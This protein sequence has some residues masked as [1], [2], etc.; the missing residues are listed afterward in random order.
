MKH[1]G[2]STEADKNFA[3][4][5]ETTCSKKKQKGGGGTTCCIPTCDSNTKR[6]PELSFYQIPTDT[7]L[8][9]VWLH[10]LVEKDLHQ[11]I[12]SSLFKTFCG[13]QEDLSS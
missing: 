8:R 9:N 13:W 3:A 4:D 12:S 2:T 11:Q 5:L 7:E 1:A 10:W 6:N